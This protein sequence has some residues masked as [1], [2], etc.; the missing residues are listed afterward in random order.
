VYPVPVG[1][2]MRVSGSLSRE[3]WTRASQIDGLR[4]LRP[5][6][7]AIYLPYKTEA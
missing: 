3:S 5:I 1:D 7:A 2:A 4:V 6:D